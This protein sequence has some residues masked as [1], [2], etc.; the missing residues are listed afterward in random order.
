MP[1]LV[2]E[3]RALER[4]V[5]ALERLEPAQERPVPA[6]ERLERRQVPGRGVPAV[7][8]VRRCRHRTE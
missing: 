2:P 5:P 7:L 1:A 6:L 3:G 8:L 4:P